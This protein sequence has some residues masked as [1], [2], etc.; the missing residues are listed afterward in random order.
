M[1][2]SIRASRAKPRAK[3]RRTRVTV[4]HDPQQA[5]TG[6]DDG[7]RADTC[8][9]HQRPSSCATSRAAAS[10]TVRPGAIPPVIAPAH[11]SSSS[12]A[13]IHGIVLEVLQVGISPREEQR[14]MTAVPPTNRVRRTTIGSSGQ[15]LAISIG[16]TDVVARDHDPVPN[17][18]THLT[19]PPSAAGP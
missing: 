10:A 18:G 7:E 6:V 11:R 16:L 14:L 9:L 8:L 1:T 12:T 19:P 3:T 5:V 13:R 15:D 2:A 4:G 17:A